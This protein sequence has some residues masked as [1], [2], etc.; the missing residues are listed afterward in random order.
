MAKNPFD[1]AR[2]RTAKGDILLREKIVMNE[3]STLL[4]MEDEATFRSALENYGLKPG[5]QQFE[6]ALRAWREA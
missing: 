5:T 3:M 4:A 2:P 6:A 1:E